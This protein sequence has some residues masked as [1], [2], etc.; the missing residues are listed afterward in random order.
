M[1]IIQTLT[2]NYNKI[3]FRKRN[4]RHRKYELRRLVSEPDNLQPFDYFNQPA[5]NKLVKLRT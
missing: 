5:V 3:T 2:H 1:D 4:A